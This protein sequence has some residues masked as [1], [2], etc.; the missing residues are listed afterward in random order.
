V[1]EIRLWISRHWVVGLFWREQGV[2]VGAS[3]HWGRWPGL[4]VDLGM[5]IVQ[6]SWM[7]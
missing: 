7:S 6:V 1:R 3:F 2:C 4:Q 5:L